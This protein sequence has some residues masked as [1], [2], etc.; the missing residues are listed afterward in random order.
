M[1]GRILI[2][3]MHNKYGERQ[4]YIMPESFAVEV[5]TNGTEIDVYFKRFVDDEKKIA[6]M[7]VMTED[8]D[9]DLLTQEALDKFQSKLVDEVCQGIC[10]HL[11]R[12]E[13][14]GPL[15]YD[16]EHYGEAWIEPT[17]SIYNSLVY[18]KSNLKQ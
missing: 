13:Q 3:T 6:S 9:T 17:K 8:C 12:R 7:V 4:V 14:D 10:K 11:L 16:L 15:F 2:M 18:D 1:N 5:E